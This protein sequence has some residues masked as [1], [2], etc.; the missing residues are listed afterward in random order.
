MRPTRAP[1]LKLFLVPGTEILLSESGHVNTH[2]PAQHGTAFPL[3]KERCPVKSFA[4]HI[5]N[6][7]V[8]LQINRFQ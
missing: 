2:F 1:E 5:A 3:T 7:G 8:L 6:F 4:H